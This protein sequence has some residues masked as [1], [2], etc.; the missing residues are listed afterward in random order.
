MKTVKKLPKKKA[1]PKKII[2]KQR[3]AD[4]LLLTMDNYSKL[5]IAYIKRIADLEHSNED[6]FAVIKKLED[7]FNNK[8]D[9]IDKLILEISDLKSDIIE[10]KD[11]RTKYNTFLTNIRSYSIFQKIFIKAK[12]DRFLNL[13]NA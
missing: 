7:K 2:S 8:T 12:I 11:K 1:A 4:I 6:A 3:A 5:E 13:I 9:R 10:F